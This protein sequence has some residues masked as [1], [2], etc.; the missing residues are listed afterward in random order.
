MEV[1]HHIRSLNVMNFP[2]QIWKMS[3]TRCMSKYLEKYHFNERV[4]ILC[5]WLIF[6]MIAQSPCNWLNLP[7]KHMLK[8]IKNQR[9]I[10][11]LSQNF[12]SFFGNWKK[13]FDYIMVI[14]PGNC[15][16]NINKTAF[17]FH[18]AI[19]TLTLS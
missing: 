11:D 12:S 5:C 6:S 2:K 19:T 4:Q 13:N 9:S 16:I 10:L 7:D 1:C 17:V 15:K 18:K 8:H 3:I 14:L